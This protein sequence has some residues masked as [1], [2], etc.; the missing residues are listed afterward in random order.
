[1][2]TRSAVRNGAEYGAALAVLKTLEW[3]PAPLAH[4]LARVY[5]AMLDAALPRLRRVGM[6]NLAA[7][8]P[9][10][11][12]DRHREIIDGVFRSIARVLVTFAKFPSIRGENVKRWIRI[13]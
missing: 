4:G 3:S 1:M 8:L 6:E 7:S 12:T 10:L 5:T 9:E 11:G 2:R 13:E